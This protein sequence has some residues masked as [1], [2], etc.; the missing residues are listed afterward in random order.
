[1]AGGEI[2]NAAKKPHTVFLIPD[3]SSDVIH[4]SLSSGPSPEAM[5]LPVEVYDDA[6]QVEICTV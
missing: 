3:L 4:L 6:L 5:D 2:W 1:M